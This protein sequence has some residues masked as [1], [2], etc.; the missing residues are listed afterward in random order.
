MNSAESLFNH[1]MNLES[2]PSLVA[3]GVALQFD[4]IY[5]RTYEKLELMG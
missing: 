5:I 1:V 4:M 2:N 3:E